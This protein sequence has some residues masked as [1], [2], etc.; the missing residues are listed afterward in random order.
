MPNE[1]LPRKLAAVLYAD[2]AGY[3]R[4]T[5]E[6]ED[7]THRRL[8]AY[9]DLFAAEVTG[10]GGRVM[11]YAGDALLA[12]FDA[13]VDAVSCALDVQKELAA[14]NAALPEDQQVEFR[15][16]VNLGDVIDDRGDVYGDG[17]NVAARLATLPGPGE[18]CVA[19]SVRTALGTR[20]DLQFADLG[21][22]RLK[23]I[24]RPVRAYRIGVLGASPRRVSAGAS[25]ASVGRVAVSK[26]GAAALL[27][28]VGGFALVALEGYL[29]DGPPGAS[30]SAAPSDAAPN[31]SVAVLPFADFSADGGQVWVADGVAEEILNSLAQLPELKVTARTSSFQFRGENRDVAEIAARL[32]VAHVLE[33]SVRANGSRLRVT[34]QLIRARDGFHVWSNAYEGTLEELFELQRVVAERVAEALDVVLDD[35]LRARMFAS[36]TQSVE[37]FRAYQEGWRLYNVAHAGSGT[38]WDANVYF[39][40]AMALDPRYSRA[41]IGR[42]DAF[43]HL[44][45]Q[46]LSSLVANAPYTQEQALAR[47]RDTFDLI[48]ASSVTETMRLAAEISRDSFTSTWQGMP[49]QLARLERSWDASAFNL[50]GGVD[51]ALWLP[52]FLLVAGRHDLVRELADRHATNDPLSVDAW[53]RK[54]LVEIHARRLDAA[55]DALAQGRRHLGSASPLDGLELLLARLDGDRAKALE[56]LARLPQSPGTA[57]VSAALR[58]DY[59]AALRIADE[60]SEV[61]GSPGTGRAGATLLAYYE[62]GATERASALVARIDA[63]VAGTPIFVNLLADS[64]NMLY[65][66][67]DDAPNFAAR[68]TEARIDPASFTLMPRLSTLP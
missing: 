50:S 31:K 49:T 32:G 22:R 35:S 51:D 67:L 39:E 36:G 1:R 62:S 53:I 13:V 44:L 18:I 9:L 56:I 4:L 24:D 47:L 16:G 8:S 45:L 63:S 12:R 5:A 23:N 28:I 38:L 64:G 17:V 58:G 15:I 55:R 48:A 61:D 34:A 54:V 27:L 33:G 40:R 68:L 57:M 52:M 29:S 11:H 26:V 41:A 14:R 20:L 7:S 2:V 25:L 66:D 60:F 46:P 10:Y 43:H 6:D 42:T 37:A 3:S 19:E 21:E 30:P 59:S 65:F